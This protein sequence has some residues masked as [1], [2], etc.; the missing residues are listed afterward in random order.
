MDTSKL[1]KFAQ[2]ARQE[3][4][5]LVSSKL[6]FV[7]KSESSA[8]REVPTVVSELEKAVKTQGEQALVDQVAYTWFNRFCA[9]RFMDVNGYNRVGVVSPTEG[10]VQPE[11]LAEAKSGII[12]EDQINTQASEKIRGLLSGSIPSPD[13]QSEAYRLLVV[14]SC[15]ALCKR[16][17][18]LFER[19]QDFTELL[20]PDDL[21]SEN[22]ILT[23]M[24]AVMTSESC[25]DVE[26][27]GW[28]YQFY[29]SEKKDEVFAGLKKNQ[30]ITAENIPAATQLFT[31][32]WI[33]R[34]LVENSLGRLWML[35]RPNSKLTEQMEYYIA[36]E[37]PETD[38]LK[39]SSP[40]ELRIADPAAGSGH[41]LTYAFDLLYA[42]Y[43]EERYDPNDIP[44]LILTNN[45]YGIEIDERAGAL[46]SFALEM[47]AAEKLGRRR[48]LRMDTKPNI[49]VLEDVGVTDSEM[50]DVMSIVGKDLYSEDLHETLTQFEQAKNFGSLIVP[51]LKDPAE[52]LRLIET[53]DLAGDMWLTEVHQRLVKVMRMAEYLSPKYHVVVANPPYKSKSDLNELLQKFLASEFP[54]GKHDLY[55][56]FIL[57]NLSLALKQGLV[58]MITM[59]GWMFSPR[60][61][62]IRESLLSRSTILG[63]AQLG[64]R[65]F[66]SIG[67]E[68]VS[69][70][71]FI[72]ENVQRL[73]YQGTFI[74]LTDGQ[75][76]AEKQSELLACASGID[77]SNRYQVSAR[78]FEKIPN[79]PIVYWANDKIRNLFTSISSISEF[80]DTRE[81]LTT[82]SNETF[83]REWHEVRV[84][85]VG[86]H[87]K[88]NEEAQR[89]QLRWFPYVK[90]GGS[91][92]WY[93]NLEHFVN[94]F[95]DGAELKA[96]KD[97]KTGRV[98][99]HNYN[100]NYGFR[101]GLTWSSISGN[102][103]AIRLV[104]AGFMFDTKGPMGF[105]KSTND[106]SQVQ[107]FLNS[108]ISS[109]LLR[110]LAPTLDYKLTHVLSLPFRSIEMLQQGKVVRSA[111]SI[112]R[113]DWDSYE[114]S[115][116]FT[117][118]PLLS[119]G[120]NAET[121]K[122]RY[123]SLR[124]Q[125]KSMTN[126]MQRLE[127]ENNRIFID[128][129]GLQDELS[130]EVPIEEI[131]LTCNPA[132][133]YGIKGTEEEREARLKADTMA[134]YLS[135]AVGCMFGRYSLD[136]PG[137]ILANQGETLADYLARI[138]EPTFMPDDDNVI[139]MID[140]EGDWFE[141]DITE[142]FKQFL[143]VSFGDEHY[144][145]N[146]AFIEDALGK[147][148]QKYF[149]KDFYNDHVQ[150]YKKRP[151]Y[152]LFSSPKGTFNALIYMHRYTPST[153]STVLN[154]YLREFRTKLEARRDS[155]DQISISASSSQK[156]KTAALKMIQKLDKV[157]DE[158]NSYEREV[159]YPLAGENIAIDLDDGVK[160]NYPLFGTALKK[161]TGLS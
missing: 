49:C 15:N 4:I 105:L 113:T 98:R 120:H 146:L 142:R 55:Q 122:D 17:P 80:I 135:Y 159:L 43:E 154:E 106:E 32:H 116:D 152:W 148:I 92:R 143:R 115:W 140:F 77:Q 97:V 75:N 102:D 87:I 57:R 46:A 61:S 68:V 100:G 123:S 111:I 81:G 84:S 59:Q 129:Y 19:I 34:Y 44:G 58:A 121:L 71:S 37:E 109:F 24:R 78:Q 117:S 158:I 51:K 52:T 119:H 133:R 150:R 103:F 28:L 12:D 67:G 26:I 25:A 64:E 83:I 99:S 160:H 85:N 53:K 65:A 39:I 76:E 112:S 161:I 131:T 139:P 124:T 40:E 54:N 27:I 149:V 11:I 137:L 88:D 1:K 38:F 7:L 8:R 145:E 13:A 134:E 21:L 62:E 41:M 125:W 101:E 3:L 36:P 82:G 128:V 35:N 93:G 118:L 45:L 31:P 157:I 114:N 18:Y 91:R 156:E 50:D 63:M 110:M 66:D 147:S 155:N 127:E 72:L 108:R 23:K 86:F 95:D 153:A 74:R 107:G 2:S 104:P 56:A 48:F 16:M 94:W 130:P 30:K 144:A 136:E 47:K 42:I 9:L 132:Y 14:G 20:M 22:S 90:G 6:A 126:E 70:T 138:P 73:A 5:E 96:F 89:K 69:T 151:I 10:Q 141:D 29:I 60:F 79:N 33:V